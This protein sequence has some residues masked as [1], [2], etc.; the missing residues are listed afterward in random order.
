MN[1]IPI[2]DI[3]VLDIS[4]HN[5]DPQKCIIALTGTGNIN[6]QSMRFLYNTQQC[7]LRIS[8]DDTNKIHHS[9]LDIPKDINADIVRSLTSTYIS[10]TLNTFFHKT[11][12]ALAIERHTCFAIYLQ[13]AIAHASDNI[14]DAIDERISADPHTYDIDPIWTNIHDI[15]Q[16]LNP[17][18]L[19]YRDPQCPHRSLLPS[20]LCQPGNW[21]NTL[22]PRQL[23]RHHWQHALQQSSTSSSHHRIAL[24]RDIMSRAEALNIPHLPTIFRG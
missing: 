22:H 13:H 8:H 3:H 6:N 5:N 23:F 2:I 16:W 10:K 20:N 17:T 14:I 15:M 19:F 9:F 18:A 11:Y 12:D 7:R 21:S 4:Y 24:L 1:N